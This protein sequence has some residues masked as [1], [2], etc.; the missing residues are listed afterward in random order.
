MTEFF[1]FGC[2]PSV[3]V[4]GNIDLRN[5]TF[6]LCDRVGAIQN[7][8]PGL[9]VQQI[10]LDRI[11]RIDILIGEEEFAL[12]QNRFGLIDALFA[13][14]FASI[15]PDNCGV[16][17]VCERANESCGHSLMLRGTQLRWIAIMPCT[18]TKK[19]PLQKIDGTLFVCR[20]SI[21]VP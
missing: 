7:C 5:V 11:S 15:Y 12:Q 14:R 13:Q 4:D 10:Q 21:C 19:E 18:Q 17:D 2:Q 16:K 3:W 9:H 1:F 6:F 8:I 20:K